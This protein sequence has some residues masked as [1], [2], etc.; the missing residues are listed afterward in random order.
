M[1]PIQFQGSKLIELYQTE[2]VSDILSGE[3]T[4]CAVNMETL[5]GINTIH[6]H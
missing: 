4:S 2:Y 6:I 3:T 1:A 5:L